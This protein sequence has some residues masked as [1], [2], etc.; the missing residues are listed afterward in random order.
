MPKGKEKDQK[1]RNLIETLIRGISIKLNPDESTL[2]VK[3]PPATLHPSVLPQQDPDNQSSNLIDK[4]SFRTEHSKLGHQ[5]ESNHTREAQKVPLREREV[6]HVD[7]DY[8]LDPDLD[9]DLDME[10]E[11]DTEPVRV[12]INLKA[13]IK[14]ALH[15]A[16]YANRNV[17]AEKWV[18]VIGLMTGYV[19]NKNTPLACL[20]VTDAYPI[21][22]GTNVNAQIQDPQSHVKVYEKKTKGEMIV[23]WYHSH[24][25]YG[26]FMSKTDYQTQVRYQKL[27][28]TES[29]L[30]APVALVIDPLKITKRSHGFKIF[31]LSKNLKEW[32][33]PRFVVLDSSLESLP[34]MLETLLPLTEGKAMFLEYDHE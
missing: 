5:D 4:D 22:H 25:N 2:T 14:I 26:A 17:Q 29:Q 21:G 9:V 32:E 27:A 31:R 1:S 11:V 20:I 7:I 18:E 23:G 28:N 15:A 6:E 30:T 19:E 10:L 13:Y 12:K 33:K 24:P 8:D 34:Q 16:K 3:I